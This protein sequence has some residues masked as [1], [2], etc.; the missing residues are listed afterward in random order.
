MAETRPNTDPERE[1]ESRAALDGG[2][3]R[4]LGR[5]LVLAVQ[6]VRL[7]SG[8]ARIGQLNL[9]RFCLG[10]PVELS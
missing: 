6:N 4:A 8:A 5:L 3:G 7:V 10:F 1:G 9:S 2:R